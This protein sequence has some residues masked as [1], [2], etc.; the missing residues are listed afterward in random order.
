MELRHLRYFVAVAEERHFGRAAERLHMAQPPLSQQIKQLEEQLGV[1]LL[2]RTTRRV[3]LT[4]AG[5][6]LLTRGTRLLADLE[7]LEQDV[8]EIGHGSAGTLR[9]GFV[10]SSTYRLMPAIVHRMS[11]EYPAVRVQISGELLTPQAEQGIMEGRLDAAVLR[12]PVSSDTIAL[13][14]LTSN[15]LMLAVP[16]SHRLAESEG[17][18]ALGDLA[19]EAIVSY[20]QDA[21]VSTTLQEAARRV[22]FR[23]HVVQRAQETST[24]VALVA[25]GLGVALLPEETR[26]LASPDSI[27]FLPLTD[28]PPVGLALAWSRT[29]PSPLLETFRTVARAA[30]VE[31]AAQE[32]TTTDPRLPEATAPSSGTPDPAAEAAAPEDPTP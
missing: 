16:R 32:A 8:R 20:S 30:A 31:M 2:E 27:R 17:P 23:P 18:V 13:Q 26:S 11:A 24:L 15:T 5:R 9:V 28:V 29:S 21:V 22:G 10:G 1:R 7:A 25:A 12:P 14:P 4:D 3:D 6:E 19:S